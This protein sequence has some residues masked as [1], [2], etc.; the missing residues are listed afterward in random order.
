V[1]GGE[2]LACDNGWTELNGLCY[3]IGTNVDSPDLFSWHSARNWCLQNGGDLAT[4]RD[5]TE[6][7][8]FANRV[9]Y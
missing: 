3:Y 8:F 9:C 2:R 4:L 6:K 7:D 5:A 1:T